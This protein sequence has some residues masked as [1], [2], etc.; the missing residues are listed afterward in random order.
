MCRVH[1]PVFD[2][3][4]STS[5]IKT[6]SRSITNEVFPTVIEENQALLE[7]YAQA[8]EAAHH[9]DE[10]HRAYVD[11]IIE[12]LRVRCRD[13]IYDRMKPHIL[14][15]CKRMIRRKAKEHPNKYLLQVKV[16]YAVEQRQNEL[17]TQRIRGILAELKPSYERNFQDLLVEII[18]FGQ[19][20]PDSSV[21]QDLTAELHKAA[22]KNALKKLPMSTNIVE[23]VNYILYDLKFGMRYERETI[24]A[25]IADMFVTDEVAQRHMDELLA[26]IQRRASLRT[27]R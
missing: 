21:F 17:R 16:K 2:R 5:E 20:D 22:L 15:G 9:L 11:A 19:S 10:E 26:S 1:Q 14:P 7:E 13:L 25:E 24:L 6:A 12:R 8:D 3:Q 4:I 27:R 23:A 18:R